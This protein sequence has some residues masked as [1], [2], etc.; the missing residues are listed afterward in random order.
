MKKFLVLLLVGALLC[1]VAGCGKT[2]AEGTTTVP[3]DTA[4]ATRDVTDAGIGSDT[5]AGTEPAAQ[6]ESAPSTEAP[7]KP[8]DLAVDTYR[9]VVD[10]YAGAIKALHD[11][12]EEDY[13]E[14]N[15]LPCPAVEANGSDLTERLADTLREMAIAPSTC[16]YAYYDVNADGT[17][18]LLF[19][20]TGL[21][22]SVKAIFTAVDGEPALVD[23][24]WSRY[25]A[26]PYGDGTLATIG[27]GGA[28]LAIYTY[29][30][31]GPDG[32]YVHT[33][34]VTADSSSGN[35]VYYDCSELGPDDAHTAGREL[36]ADEVKAFRE[37]VNIGSYVL[38]PLEILPLNA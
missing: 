2:P 18:D 19:L 38:P 36:T 26:F 22:T 29:G 4:E 17:S 9:P 31:F 8:S 30:T 13:F 25:N 37:A 6:T 14:A 34:N 7:T 5:D 1:A 12:T 35:T 23:A 15:P 24:F 32:A 33:W 10:W 28:E 27:S 3:N 11:E 16:G 21:E 20:N